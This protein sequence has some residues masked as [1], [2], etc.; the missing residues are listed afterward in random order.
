MNLVNKAEKKTS[1]KSYIS[2]DSIYGKWANLKY[3]TRNQNNGIL[4]QYTLGTISLSIITGLVPELPDE[5]KI[6]EC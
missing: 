1:T 4:C 6:W 2:L 5:T 3:H